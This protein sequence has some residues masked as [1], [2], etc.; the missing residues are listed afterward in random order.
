MKMVAGRGKR[1][2]GGRLAEGAFGYYTRAAC[3]AS[4]EWRENM[5]RRISFLAVVLAGAGILTVRGAGL[6]VTIQPSRKRI[7]LSDKPAPLPFMHCILAGST[8]YRGVRR[9]IGAHK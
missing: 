5:N 2:I 1:G 6:Q 7:N 3:R 8:L 4:F 9:W